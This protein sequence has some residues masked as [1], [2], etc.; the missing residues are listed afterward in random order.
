[1]EKQVIQYL[2]EQGFQVENRKIMP[3]DL[4]SVDHVIMTNSLI[5]VVPVL[6]LDGEQLKSNPDFCQKIC[7]AVLKG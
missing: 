5:G 1:M 2:A 7:E 4:F 3:E 6:S